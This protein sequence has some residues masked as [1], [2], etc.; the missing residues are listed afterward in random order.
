MQSNAFLEFYGA[1]SS[2]AAIE[3]RL[4]RCW[5]IAVVLEWKVISILQRRHITESFP[6]TLKN[7]HTLEE[8][9]R[10]ALHL[11]KSGEPLALLLRSGAAHLCF[12]FFESTGIFRVNVIYASTSSIT[13]TRRP[14]PNPNSTKAHSA[15]KHTHKPT[16]TLIGE[17]QTTKTATFP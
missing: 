6:F 8:R 15:R 10:G 3:W 16:Q 13:S 7:S 11:W 12:G 2:A 1:R 4:F 17:V 14:S 5:W 9:V